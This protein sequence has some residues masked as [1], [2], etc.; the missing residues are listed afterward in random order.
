MAANDPAERGKA[1]NS[2]QNYRILIESALH[3][4]ISECLSKARDG[5]AMLFYRADERT[6]QIIKRDG[7]DLWGLAQGV[8]AEKGG[9]VQYLQEQ[10]YIPFASGLDLSEW[11]RVLS[12]PSR[13]TISTSLDEGTGGKNGYTYKIEFLNLSTVDFNDTTMGVTR[14]M[15]PF[16]MQMY[17]SGT[18]LL[19]AAGTNPPTIA[20]DIMLKTQ[21]VV[22]FTKIQ[23]AN[24][25]GW[26]NYGETTFKSMASVTAAPTVGK[27][28][29]NIF[30]QAATNPAPTK[31]ISTPGKL[32]ANIFQTTPSNAVP[33]KSTGGTGKIKIPDAF[34]K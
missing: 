7:F 5:D 16:E 1:A 28:Q 10:V 25:I 3:R 11:V 12:N 29:P 4:V 31:P 34:N 6:P 21:E 24:I 22:F 20:L 18:T 15:K 26:R 8:V 9:I 14:I 2:T 13:P 17:L 32:T 33:G 30:Q 23:P 27:L 19:L